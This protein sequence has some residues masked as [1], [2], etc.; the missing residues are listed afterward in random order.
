MCMI[1][2]SNYI[3]P[4]KPKYNKIPDTLFYGAQALDADNRLYNHYCAFNKEGKVLGVIDGKMETLH[5]LDE[6]YFPGLKKIRSFN[7]Y[8]IRSHQHNFGK[9]LLDFVQVLSRQ[10][11]G[12]GRFHLIASDCYNVDKPPHIFYRKYGMNS[13]NEDVI[14][15]IDKFISGLI[16]KENLETIDIPMYYI[17]K[18]LEKQCV[19]KKRLSFLKNL[20]KMFK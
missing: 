1:N 4:L 3:G 19:S 11:G 17:Q 10:N 6:T 12:E 15:N 7:V 8:Y 2:S 5:P 18:K 20:L 16:P 14:R 13:I 9:N